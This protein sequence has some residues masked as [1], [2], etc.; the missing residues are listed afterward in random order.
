MAEIILFILQKTSIYSRTKR[1]NYEII[2][3]Y[4]NHQI[5][6]NVENKF[7]LYRIPS[8]V[9]AHTAKSKNIDLCLII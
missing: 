9:N 7:V 8:D 6:T 4:Q 1:A 2:F 5:L 3:N